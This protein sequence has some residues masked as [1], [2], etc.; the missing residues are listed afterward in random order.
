MDGPIRKAFTCLKLLSQCSRCWSSPT[1]RTSSRWRSTLELVGGRWRQSMGSGWSCP[2]SSLGD[3][4]KDGLDSGSSTKFAGLY[5]GSCD[6][7]TPHWP[8]L[9][10]T[11]GPRP[12]Q[13]LLTLVAFFSIEKVFR[14]NQFRIS[15][16]NFP[17]KRGSP[18]LLSK[19]R[20]VELWFFKWNKRILR[21]ASSVQIWL[22]CH[23][24]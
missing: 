24:E 16:A 2:R 6:S 3:I 20:E 17:N 4:P 8:R 9:M 13:E 19:L 1:C 12:Q 18:W 14:L 22:F 23:N 10:Q 21:V 5:V 11:L 7:K 15:Q